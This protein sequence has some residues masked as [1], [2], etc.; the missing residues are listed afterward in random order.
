MFETLTDDHGHRHGRY[1]F[2][3]DKDLQQE[4]VL[5]WRRT[6][7]GLVERLTND[8]PESD[9]TE[10][11]KRAFELLEDWN[12]QGRLL[13]LGVDRSLCIIPLVAFDPQGEHRECDI[14]VWDTHVEADADG[15]GIAEMGTDTKRKWLNDFYGRVLFPLS[16]RPDGDPLSLINV[17]FGSVKSRF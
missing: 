13:V 12:G 2:V 5:H 7:D 17:E 16:K 8:A 4:A 3:L 10:L 11:R 14:Y 1:V 6:L 15:H 9:A